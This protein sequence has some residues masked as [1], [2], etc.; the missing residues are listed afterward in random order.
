MR[1]TFEKAESQALRA[2]LPNFTTYRLPAGELVLI[3]N[4]QIGCPFHNQHIGQESD[5]SA[6]ETSSQKYDDDR[7]FNEMLWQDILLP[8][9]HAAGLLYESKSADQQKPAGDDA[10]TPLA[11][12]GLFSRIDVSP[13]QLTRDPNSYMGNMRLNNPPIP[14]FSEGR[15]MYNM[16]VATHLEE[17][18]AA[19]SF[20]ASSPDDTPNQRAYIEQISRQGAVCIIKDRGR[21]EGVLCLALEN[22]P[23]ITDLDGMQVADEA[24]IDVIKV[25]QKIVPLSIQGL[26]DQPCRWRP[27]WAKIAFVQTFAWPILIN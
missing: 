20:L 10:F 19:A 1:F 8:L 11:K 18:D 23:G 4:P 17:L 13:T 6:Y 16:N 12:I 21:V 7:R 3:A 25:N 24:F 15:H 22:I 26:C 9:Y 14:I 27:R 2:T 5:Q